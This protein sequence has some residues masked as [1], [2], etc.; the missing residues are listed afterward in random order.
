MLSIRKLTVTG[1]VALAVSSCG[2]LLWSVPALAAAFS[3]E[4]SFGEAGSGAGQFE[5]PRA[6]AVES[7]TGDVFVNSGVDT[8]D[9]QTVTLSGA[10]AGTFALAFEGESTGAEGEGELEE[11]SNVVQVSNVTGLFVEGEAISGEGIKPGTLIT[12]AS[13]GTV[14]LSKAATETKT[15]VHL[16]AGLPYNASAGTVQEVL[17]AL[18]AI[19]GAVKVSGEEGGPY[20]VEFAEALKETTVAV[21]TCDASGLNVGA[22]CGVVA[23]PARNTRRVEKFAG[24]TYVG[25]VTA[26]EG[27]P[28]KEDSGVGIAV[29]N[30]TG[31]YKGYVYIS[32]AEYVD[33]FAPKAGHPNE[34]EFVHQ[35]EPHNSEVSVTVDPENGDLYVV[36][37]VDLYV[38][39]PDGT[40]LFTQEVSFPPFIGPTT[41]NGHYFYGVKFSSSFVEQ[42]LVSYEVNASTHEL[43]N[44]TTI[45]TELPL[46]GVAVGANGDVFALDEAS[47]GVSHVQVFAP[48]PGASASPI[49]EF[50]TGEIGASQGI[51]AS[52]FNRDVYVS[53]L[54]SSNV[55][56]YGHQSSGE[57]PSVACGPAK[58]ARVSALVDCTIEPNAAEASWKLEYRL[59]G[60][61]TFSVARSGTATAAGVVGGEIPGLTPGTAYEWRLNALNENGSSPGE[62]GTF[63]T[64]PVVAGVTPCTAGTPVKAEGATFTASLEPEGDPTRWVFQYGVGGYGSES[65]G[66]STS[67]GSVASVEASVT[68]LIPNATYDCRLVATSEAGPTAGQ[69]TDGPLGEFTTPL[70]PPRVDDVP[71]QASN[72]TRTSAQLSGTVDPE[73]SA[74]TYHFVY[75]TDAGYEPLAPDPYAAGGETPAASAGAGFGDAQVGPVSLS[76]LAPDTTY[77][78][79]LVASNAAL[80][81]TVMGSDHTFTTAFDPPLASTGEASAVTQSAAAISGTVEPR[82]IPTTYR[83]E[84]GTDTAYNGAP[85]LGSAGEGEG[86]GAITVTLEDLAPGTT[87]HYRLTA[88]NTDGASYGRDMTFTTPSLPSPI[89]QPLTL[90]LLATPN[91]SFPAETTMTPTVKKTVTRA[92]KLQRALKVCKREK[93][94]SKRATCERQAH[95]RYG[96]V[97][98]KGKKNGKA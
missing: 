22:G 32:T 71:A 84:V 56:V 38:Y 85:I 11:E 17:N 49:E 35:F 30:S 28:L 64:L 60:S 51:A 67:S 16:K 20:T 95:K 5:E 52:A 66:G 57:P 31:P 12:E 37:S 63:V 19:G 65:A 58:P 91:V 46:R 13:G 7:S 21:M 70:A 87:Y 88:S 24:S 61:G 82:G 4:G 8:N 43:E 97:R 1:L 23:E 78:Y 15:G 10:T 79:A 54:T 83:F 73:H 90:P 68:G 59:A 94:R 3:L 42:A 27:K 18:S 47:P 36:S 69:S 72:I 96:P 89:L 48:N 93:S 86:P 29:D 40:K 98:T 34:Y 33:Q 53:D 41:I 2:L 39:E 62:R 14:K 81:G 25:E 92:Q 75:V 76:E 50:G 26:P 45:E 55:H 74:T 44:E 77:H 9:V 80:G 6:V